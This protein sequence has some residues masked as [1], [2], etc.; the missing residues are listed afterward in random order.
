[1]SG[2]GA[3]I[4]AYSPQD[5]SIRAQPSSLELDEVLLPLFDSNI[6]NIPSDTI[7]WLLGLTLRLSCSLG[8]HL[9]PSLVKL[10]FQRSTSEQRAKVGKFEGVAVPVEETRISAQPGVGLVVVWVVESSPF[11]SHF[12]G[13]SS[14]VF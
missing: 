6:I 3:P 7:G 12:R 4:R 2:L 11:A 13:D 10:G 8:L 1:M 9:L 14:A 5:T